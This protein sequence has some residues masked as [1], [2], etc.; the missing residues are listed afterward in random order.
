[1]LLTVSS[2][3]VRFVGLCAS[4]LGN[5]VLSVGVVSKASP[6]FS[7]SSSFALL[8]R[9]WCF[10]RW[11]SHYDTYVNIG[12]E[13]AKYLSADIGRRVRM[14]CIAVEMAVTW[15]VRDRSP[16]GPTNN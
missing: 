7:F 12:Y 5:L 6:V 3:R 10:S 9:S 2:P 4:F 16:T 8:M 15:F 13:S 11:F 14:I 1:M